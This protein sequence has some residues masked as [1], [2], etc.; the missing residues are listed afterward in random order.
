MHQV[1]AQRALAFALLKCQS[2]ECFLN[3]TRETVPVQAIYVDGVL[4][5]GSLGGPS[6]CYAVVVVNATQYHVVRV[7]AKA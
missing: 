1:G 6:Q 2:L 5:A 3:A 4:V 7:C